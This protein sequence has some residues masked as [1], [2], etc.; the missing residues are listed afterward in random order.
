MK[1]S[2]TKVNRKIRDVRFD[3]VRAIHCVEHHDQLD[4]DRPHWA[5][6][7]KAERFVEA[8]TIRLRDAQR[9]LE[10]LIRQKENEEA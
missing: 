6:L 8:A 9:E 2:K 1:T 4:M 10:K 7:Q 5:T 3:L